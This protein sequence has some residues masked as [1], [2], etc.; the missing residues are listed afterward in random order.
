MFFSFLF[1]LEALCLGKKPIYL[2]REIRIYPQDLLK[3]S[4]MLLYFGDAFFFFF[5]YFSILNL[6]SAEILQGTD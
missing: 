3:Q 1:A 4:R 6:L 5:F 2:L